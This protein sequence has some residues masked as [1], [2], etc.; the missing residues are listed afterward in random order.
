[1]KTEIKVENVKVTIAKP[2]IKA[3][4][5]PVFIQ[6]KVS[7]ETIAKEIAGRI[8]GKLDLIGFDDLYDT[9]TGKFLTESKLKAVG[10]V[11]ITVNYNKVLGASDTVK[12]SRLTG[13]P[14]PYIRKTSKFQ[15]IGNVNWQSFVNKRGHGDFVPAE[16]RSNGVENFAECKAVGITKSGN[17]T[18][19]G[20]AFRVLESSKYFDENGNEYQDIDMLTKEYLK[21]QS[22]E[23][24]QKESEK[25]GIDVKFDPKYRTVRIDSCD[26]V[27]C[28]GFDYQPTDNQ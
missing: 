9:K 8:T 15:I 6:R 16:N 12:K 27:R 10:A 26:S 20:V 24:K 1:M 23:S 5:T 21:V 3:D 13:N 22:D 2:E 4:K 14:T 19:N 17:F 18:L 28:F 11:F 25:H 7:S